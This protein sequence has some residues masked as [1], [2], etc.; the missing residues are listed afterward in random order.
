MR[1]NARAGKVQLAPIKRFPCPSTQASSEEN[2]EVKNELEISKSFCI[3]LGDGN[4]LTNKNIFE[5]LLGG[6]KTQNE[7]LEEENEIEKPW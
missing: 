7:V 1:R 5:I 6:D 3:Q 2:E 4:K